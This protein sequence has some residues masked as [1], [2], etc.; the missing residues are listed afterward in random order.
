MP[1]K[2][3]DARLA[4]QR[5]WKAAWR[6]ANPEKRAAEERA[7]RKAHPGKANAKKAR[8]IE[9]HPDLAKASVAR[10][11]TRYYAKNRQELLLDQRTYRESLPEEI[12]QRERDKSAAYQS[13]VSLAGRPKPDLCEA[14]GKS[15]DARGLVFDHCHAKGHFRG[16]LCQRCNTALGMVDDDVQTLLKLAAYLE[17]N[18]ENT[19]PQLSLIGI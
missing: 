7:Y 9:K 15:P 11:W 13:R 4:Y 5:A 6:K 2:D 12:K 10:R 3:K 16:W 14:C 17:R 18:K 8:W 19:A 1:L